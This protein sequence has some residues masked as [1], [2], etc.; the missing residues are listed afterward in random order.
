MRP[1]ILVSDRRAGF[2]P[3]MLLAFLVAGLLRAQNAAPGAPPAPSTAAPAQPSSWFNAQTRELGLTGFESIAEITPE[4]YLRTGFGELMFFAGPNLEPTNVGG[5]IHVENG[6]PVVHAEFEHDG[7]GYRFT[8]FAGKVDRSAIVRARQ[9]AKFPFMPGFDIESGIVEPEVD[10]IR[11]EIANQTKEQRRAVLASGFRYQ[12][13]NAPA[14]PTGQPGEAFNRGWVNYFD[15]ANFYRF[16]RDLYI[17]PPGFIDRSFTIRKNWDQPNP[18]YVL[19]VTHVDAAPDTPVGIVTYA[20]QLNAGETWTMDFKMPLIPTADP[21]V[22]S[23]ID[24][25][26][27]DD[28]EAQMHGGAAP[29][30]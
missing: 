8:I 13:P 3:V 6:L 7:I 22:I 28:V 12:D 24:D 11:V 23:A 30:H 4:G 10:F 14:A 25:A 2:V 27:F 26:K 15:D 19:G 21:F 9:H 5:N 1:L 20:R 29:A 18:Q 16:N 17:F